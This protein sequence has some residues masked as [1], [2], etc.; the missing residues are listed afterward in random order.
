VYCNCCWSLLWS[1]VIYT[2]ESSK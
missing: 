1:L 2:N